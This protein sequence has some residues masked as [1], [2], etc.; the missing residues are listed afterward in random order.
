[1]SSLETHTEVIAYIIEQKKLGKD[2][3]AVFADL[4]DNHDFNGVYARS[5]VES[6]R[7]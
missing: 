1:M 4:V 6:V 3:E 5:A 7:W 2:K